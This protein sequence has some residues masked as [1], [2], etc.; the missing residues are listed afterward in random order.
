MGKI[1]Q[2]YTIRQQKMMKSFAIAS[3]AALQGAQALRQSSATDG[4]SDAALPYGNWIGK[5]NFEGATETFLTAMMHIDQQCGN[6]GLMDFGC[7]I[8]AMKKGVPSLSEVNLS[9]LQSLISEFGEDYNWY[10]DDWVLGEIIPLAYD[11]NGDGLLNKQEARNFF[12]LIGMEQEVDAMFD[13]SGVLAADKVVRTV[14]AQRYGGDQGSQVDGMAEAM[15]LLY[16]L[17]IN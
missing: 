7:L 11:S 5:Y 17:D 10:N 15:Q 9:H 12:R 13:Q 16:H 8:E 14:L 6:N 4:S 3:L 1:N 2:K